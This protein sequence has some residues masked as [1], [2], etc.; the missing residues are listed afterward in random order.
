MSGNAT[1]A[2]FEIEVEGSPLPDSDASAVYGVT[3]DQS[4]DAPNRCVIALNPVNYPADTLRGLDFGVFA[5]GASLSV[6]LGMGTA[7]PVF[8]GLITAVEPSYADRCRRVNITAYDRTYLLQFGTKA[9]IFEEMTYS[10]IAGEVLDEAGLEAE[11]EPTSAVHAYVPQI[12]L[13]DYRFLISI[14]RRIGYELGMRNDVVTFRK[15]RLDDPPVV[16]LEYGL[17]LSEFN[18]RA[19]ALTRGSTVTRLGWDP[20]TK[21]VLEASVS[22]AEPEDRMGGEETGFQMSQSVE[23]SPVT[24]SDASIDDVESAQELA[25]GAR[26]DLLDN[27]ITGE[28]RSTGDALIGAGSVV[29]ISGIGGRF[30]G[31]YYVVAAIHEFGIDAGYT[32]RSTL[33]R[34]GI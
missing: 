11:V 28:A 15:A 32:T 31:P 9:R 16:T 5:M 17:G 18:T 13:S 21:S 22:N 10:A 24:G 4:L 8:S 6:S 19:R 27:F 29:E 7:R 14:A 23:P 12:N 33:R 25:G 34:T 20:K 2:A 26:D 3:V 1:G 30:D